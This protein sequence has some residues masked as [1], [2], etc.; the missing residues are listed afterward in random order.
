MFILVGLGALVESAKVL[1]VVW[2]NIPIN[3]GRL[4]ARPWYG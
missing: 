4:G 3:V 1:W 2:P